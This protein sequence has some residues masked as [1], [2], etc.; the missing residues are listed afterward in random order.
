MAFLAMFVRTRA[1]LSSI[2]LHAGTIAA[3]IG[4]SGCGQPVPTQTAK[5][6][7]PASTV[8][9]ASAAKAEPPSSEPH[10]KNIKQLTFGGENAEA[11]WSFDGEQ[12]IMQ[13]HQG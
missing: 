9:V 12:L 5:R 2:C 8:P 1:H 10:L 3:L 7:Q 6:Q 13:A 4:A 11:Y